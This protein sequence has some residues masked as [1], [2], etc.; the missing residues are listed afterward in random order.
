MGFF[1]LIFSL[2]NFYDIFHTQPRAVLFIIIIIIILTANGFVPGG[3]GTTIRHNT[4]N[5]THRTK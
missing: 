5:N 3:N 1:H 4:Q 2:E